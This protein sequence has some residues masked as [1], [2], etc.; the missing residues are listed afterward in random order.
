MKDVYL[1]QDGVEKIQHELKRLID[2]DRKDIIKKIKE[3]RE[4]GD[5]SENSEYEAARSEQSIIEGR[6][7]EIQAL[8]KNAQ[9]IHATKHTAGKVALGDKVDVEIEKEKGSFTLVGSAESD[10][11]DGLISIESPLG[12]ALLGSQVGEKVQVSIPDGGSVEYT[13]LAINK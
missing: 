3:S 10:P 5:L 4:Y 6:I 8:L 2:V 12:K 7:L 9:I 1:T 13:I 11:A